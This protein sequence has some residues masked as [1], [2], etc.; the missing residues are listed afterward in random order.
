V[1]L[2]LPEVRQGDVRIK[3]KAVSFNPVD[4]QIRKGQPESSY[5]Q[6]MILGRDLAGSVDAVHEDVT[7]FRV[8]DEVFSYVCNLS[9]SGTYT[10]QVSVP[11]E[12]VA[13][14]PASL[15]PEQAAAVPVAGITASIALDKAQ[16]GKATSVFIAGGAGGVGTFAIRLAR[17]RG[18]QNLV[19]TAGNARSGRASQRGASE[20]AEAVG[21]ARRARAPL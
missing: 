6:S 4:Y 20:H 16:A 13:R 12:L 5:I 1:N 11:A 21:P 9:S 19:T 15:T 3:V 18:M 2:P 17:Q 14:K 10:E 8:G 7:D